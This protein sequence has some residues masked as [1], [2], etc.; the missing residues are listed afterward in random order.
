MSKKKEYAINHTDVIYKRFLNLAIN[1]FKWEGLPEGLS[2]RKLEEMLINNGKVMFFKD[3]NSGIFALECEGT[4]KYNVYNEPTVYYVHGNQYSKHVSI[5]DGVV[6]RNN[7]TGTGDRDDLRIFAERINEVEQTMDINLNA[8]KTPYIIL[9]DE[10]QRL[11]F[12]NILQQVMEFKYAIFGNRETI[13]TTPIEVLS[14]NT[15]Y[16]LEQLQDHK[17]SLM[18]ELLTFLG[19]NNNNTDKKERLVVDEV[20]ANNEFILVNIDHMLEERQLACKMINA[21]FGLS[22]TVEKREVDISGTL[23]NGIERDSE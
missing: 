21:K 22:I 1:R 15:P 3:T 12:K 11:T 19:I 4:N 10:K 13:R 6:M 20:N 7:S 8:Q 2:S 9:C 17:N 14:T 23:H 18:N 16:L 5:D